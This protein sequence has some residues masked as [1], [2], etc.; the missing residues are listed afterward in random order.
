MAIAGQSG[1][2]LLPSEIKLLILENLPDV[3]TLDSIEE[4]SPSMKQISRA[5]YTRVVTAVTL[6]EL[7]NRDIDIF[8]LAHCSLVEILAV[9]YKSSRLYLSDDLEAAL[10]SLKAQM[11]DPQRKVLLLDTCSCLA[12]REI[13]GLVRWNVCF[14][15]NRVVSTTYMN[16]PEADDPYWVD[17]ALVR[18]L[19]LGDEMYKRRELQWKM[20]IQRVLQGLRRYGFV[21]DSYS[22]AEMWA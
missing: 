10:R 1:L 21:G 3:K 7:V 15:E 22:S 11:N 18:S 6:N 5:L 19:Y 13:R 9:S 20:Y 14:D 2:E 4:A 12:L 16:V 8:S 17:H